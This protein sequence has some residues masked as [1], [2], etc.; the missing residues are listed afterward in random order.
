MI[1]MLWALQC[2]L[3][4]MLFSCVLASATAFVGGVL[5]L[6]GSVANCIVPIFYCAAV[7]NRFSR[8]RI[9]SHVLPFQMLFLLA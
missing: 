3:L 9:C 7:C 2:M 1:V 8:P 5:T 4:F 6:G